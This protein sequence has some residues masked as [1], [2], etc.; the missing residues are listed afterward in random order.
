MSYSFQPGAFQLDVALLAFALAFWGFQHATDP[1]F[2]LGAFWA[3]EGA[4]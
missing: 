4:A 1:A 3:F 2:Q